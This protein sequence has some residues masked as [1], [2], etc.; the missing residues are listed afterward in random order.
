MKGICKGDMLCSHQSG[1]GLH[2]SQQVM[3]QWL[4][5]IVEKGQDFGER[6]LRG[7]IASTSQRNQYK[8]VSM[9]RQCLAS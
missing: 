5:R 7:H 8:L 1:A 3:H 6:V 2:Q 4:E 9:Q